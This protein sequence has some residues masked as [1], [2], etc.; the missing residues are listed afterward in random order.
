MTSASTAR[1]FTLI[2]VIIA[3]FIVSVGA[4]CATIAVTMIKGTRESTYRSTAIRIAETELNELRA[5]GYASLPSSEAFTSAELSGLP[6]GVASTTVTTWNAETKQVTTGV[7]WQGTDDR[8]HYVSLH[9]LVTETGG[10]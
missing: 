2:E 9:T 1:G 6:Q 10:L 5:G 8:T 4:V 3:L 7:A